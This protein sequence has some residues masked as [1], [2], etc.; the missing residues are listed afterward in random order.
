MVTRCVCCSKTFAELKAVMQQRNLRT[1]EELKAAVRFGENCKQCF[2]YIRKMI[3]T[4]ETAFLPISFPR[5]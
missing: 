5:N 4:G 3:E 1:V 2:P